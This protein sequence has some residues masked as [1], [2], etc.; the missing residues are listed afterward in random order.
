MKNAL[1]TLSMIG[2]L[3]AAATAKAADLG[4]APPPP[5]APVAAPFFAPFAPLTDR[6]PQ[7][8]VQLGPTTD[9]STINCANFVKLPDGT[10]QATAPVPF[11]LG[12]VNDIIPPVRPIKSGGFIYNNIDLYS[13]LNA[14]CGA[15]VVVR[16]KY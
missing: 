2:L 12:F 6:E 1:I 9:Y 7:V 16:A 11:S 14:Q 10:W 13:Q 5:M 15:G 3:G 8:V 4:V